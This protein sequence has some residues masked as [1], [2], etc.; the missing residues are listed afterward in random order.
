MNDEVIRERK[1]I[2]GIADLLRTHP[3]TV[4]CKVKKN[5]KGIRVIFEVTQREMQD[6][7]KKILEK[8]EGK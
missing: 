1:I 8:K 4:E 5:P 3:F 7:A 2:Q 6:I